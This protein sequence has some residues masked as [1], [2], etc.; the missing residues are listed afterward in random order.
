MLGVGQ[1]FTLGVEVERTVG[2]AQLDATGV[3]A[4]V[5]TAH[6]SPLEPP[7]RVLRFQSERGSG[8]GEGLAGQSCQHIRTESQ[9]IRIHE[10]H[11]RRQTIQTIKIDAHRSI[12]DA[13]MGLL[14]CHFHSSSNSN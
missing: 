4:Q 12:H 3:A 5:A 10:A 11:A 13:W 14:A 7:F 8:G 9:R 1:P 2:A 6:T